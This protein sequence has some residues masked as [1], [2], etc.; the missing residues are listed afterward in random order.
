[1]ESFGP[2]ISSFTMRTRAKPLFNHKTPFQTTT[3]SCLFNLAYKG[4]LVDFGSSFTL[5]GYH[6]SFDQISTFTYIINKRTW[7]GSTNRPDSNTLLFIR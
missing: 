2:K 6:Q 4:V 5:K 7:L 1:M 3:K